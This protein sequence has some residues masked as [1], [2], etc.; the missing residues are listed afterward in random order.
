MDGTAKTKNFIFQSSHFQ[1][2]YL[3][4]QGEEKNEFLASFGG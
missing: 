1:S 4:K 3:V 2:Q